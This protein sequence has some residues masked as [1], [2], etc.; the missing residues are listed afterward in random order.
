MAIDG[1]LLTVIKSMNDL[2][3]CTVV[4]LHRVTGISRPA[5][6]RI[7]DSLCAYGYTER[8]NGKSSIRLTSQVLA[9]SAGYKPENRLGH[10]VLPV[11]ERVQQRVRWPHTFATPQDNMMV[12]QETTRERNPFVFDSGRTGMSLPMV[13][14]AIGCAYL[15][16]CN[17]DEREAVLARWLD[18][19]AADTDRDEILAAARSRIANATEKGFALRSG[20]RPERTS[21]LA[22]PVIICS[23][24]MGALCTTFPTSAVSLEEV[25]SIY[26]PELKAAARSVSASFEN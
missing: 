26:V 25:Y 19:H 20:G 5:I 9:L 14:T 1:R 10:N 13:S 24:V 21:T 12:I 7:V 17:Q 15:A 23:T 6:H 16:F 18:S 22:V 8:V 3:V 11:L 2:G 4:D